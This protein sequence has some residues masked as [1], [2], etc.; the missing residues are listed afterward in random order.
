M[1]SILRNFLLS[2]AGIALSLTAASAAPWPPAKG[3]L[4]L[5]VQATGGTGATTNVFFNLGPAHTIRDTPSPGL[6]VNLDAELVAAFGAGWSARTDLYFGVIANR[7]NATPSG[8]GSVAPENGDPARTIYVSR[9]AATAGTAPAWSGFSV[10]ALGIAATGHAGQI[11]AIDNLTANGNEVAT[12]SQ[13]ANPVEWANGW[14]AFNPTP[15]AAYSTFSGGIQANIN[16]TAAIVDVFRIVSTSGVG[17]YVTSV[18]LAANGDVTVAAAGAPVSYFTVTPTATNG[19]I[20]GAAGPDIVYASG[21]V[22]KLTAVPATGFGFTGW[23]GD[24]SGTTNPFNLTMDGNKNV[25]ANFAAFPSV[26]TPTATDITDTEATLGGD[27]TSD[28]GSSVTERGVVYSINS[29]N[30]NPIIDGSG[31]TKATTSGTTGVFTVPVTGLAPAT[32]YAFKAY[33]TSAVGTAYTTVG[34]F[35]TDTAVI[36]TSGIGNVTGRQILAGDTQSFT[37]TLGSAAQTAISALN[38]AT[39]SGELFDSEGNSVATGSGNFAISELL[40]AG[41]YTLR[42]TA[43]A[44]DETFSLNFDASNQVTVAPLVTVAPAT[45]ISKK[46]KPVSGTA[47]IRNNSVLT[48]TFRVS[49]GAGN[50][51][52]GAAYFDGTGANVTAALI[53]GTYETP[54]LDENA[55]P[56]SI[57]AAITPNKKKIVKKGKNGK[58]GKTLKKTFRSTI[59][60]TSVTTPAISAAGQLTVKTK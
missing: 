29:T 34:H 11:N 57:R 18:T 49:A 23:G 42:M 54:S 17:T 31:V 46:A 50:G 7:S 41:T 10:S 52:F 26:T 58:K 43:G 15:G 32:T 4:I 39:L 36:L 45:I 53:T 20:A 33:A 56:V 5:G 51:L 25:T 38:A 37:F 16:A 8:L 55:S 28:G 12:L 19:S 24:A 1:K 22:A 13:G 6:A 35:T 60:A 27:V 47:T 59:R 14:T 21:S 9:G 30:N 2:A 40:E 3:D 44:S 48:D